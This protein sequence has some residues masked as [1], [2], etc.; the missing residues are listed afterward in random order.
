VGRG[1]GGG[2]VI[3]LVAVAAVLGLRG[4]RR[5][6]L[7]QAVAKGFVHAHHGQQ[8]V[9][10]DGNVDGVLEGVESHI[11]VK[12][13]DASYI[14]AYRV[15]YGFDEDVVSP[16]SVEPESVTGLGRDGG[17]VADVF[18]VIILDVGLGMRIQ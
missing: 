14:L 8:L 13:T 2:L 16:S 15:R 5:P 7:L 3:I 18:Y 4:L 11:V 9:H 12:T 1:V 17:A 10:A 6:P